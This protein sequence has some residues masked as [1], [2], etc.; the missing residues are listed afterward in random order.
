MK[1]DYSELYKKV[2]T[3]LDAIKTGYKQGWSFGMS[4]VEELTGR[5]DRGQLWVLGGYPGV[6]KS[7]FVLNLID[8]LLKNNKDLKILVF[9]TELTPV[10]YV[11][12]HVL[13]RAGVFKKSFETAPDRWFNFVENEFENYFNERTLNE[14][15]LDIRGD[16]T[17]FEQIRDIKLDYTPDIIIT[18]YVQELSIEGARGKNETMPLLAN[19][20]KKLAIKNKAACICVTQMTN[21]SSRDNTATSQ[22]PGFDYGKEFNNAAHVSIVLTRNKFENGKQSRHLDVHVV[23]A[24]DGELGGRFLE[25]KGGYNLEEINKARATELDKEVQN[26]K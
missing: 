5:I 20:F 19:E 25:I 14:N 17:S 1:T 13:M 6:G 23:K 2:S 9:S 8:N 21:A 11:Y 12:R 16:I 10:T 26:G 22:L 18:D 4:N 3:K 7:Y 24:R 15:S